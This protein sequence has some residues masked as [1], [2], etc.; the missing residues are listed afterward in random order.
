MVNYSLDNYRHKYDIP[1]H[2]NNCDSLWI[3]SIN[4]N[5][6]KVLTPIHSCSICFLGPVP[7]LLCVVTARRNL[8]QPTTYLH[9]KSHTFI[10]S[11]VKHSKLFK[12]RSYWL[13]HHKTLKTLN[14]HHHESLNSP[15]VN[16]ICF[17]LCNLISHR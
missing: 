1:E 16:Y 10:I 9:N 3:L 5:F 13:W 4:V 11:L 6:I 7:T 17:Y 12:S 15:I 8:Q 14:L 2:K